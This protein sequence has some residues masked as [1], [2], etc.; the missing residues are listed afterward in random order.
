MKHSLIR[1]ALLQALDTMDHHEDDI[2]GVHARVIHA[3]SVNEWL[4][5]QFTFS[6][7]SSTT[8]I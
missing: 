6:D 5:V 3:T 7:G 8:V 1:E 2:E 4:E